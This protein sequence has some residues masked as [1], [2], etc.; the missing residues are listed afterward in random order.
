MQ[1]FFKVKESVIQLF[2]AMMLEVA[3]I[4]MASLVMWGGAVAHS[5]ELRDW[6]SGDIQGATKVGATECAD[7]HDTI[8]ANAVMPKM[9]ANCE[10]CHGGGSKHIDSQEPVDIR[11]PRDEDCLA[12][13]ESGKST[14]LSWRTSAHGRAGLSCKDCHNPHGGGL[15]L[16]RAVKTKFGLRNIDD[17]SARCVTCHTEIASRLRLPSHHPVAEGA[18]SCVDCHNP[19]EDTRT[20]LGDQSDRCAKCHQDYLGPWVFEHPP[21]VEDCTLCHNPHG[22]ASTNLEVRIQPLLCIQCHSLND[23][24]HASGEVNP[25]QPPIGIGVPAPY[26]PTAGGLFQCTNCHGAIHGSHNDK[27]LRR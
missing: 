4:A 22:S 2:A 11:F 1:S 15:K 7:C 25:P 17:L 5:A 20:T 13:H 21:V 12:C 16:I 24:R 19:H 10:A 8:Q 23:A 26:L 6:R 14:H 27:H 3:F 9:H 18:L